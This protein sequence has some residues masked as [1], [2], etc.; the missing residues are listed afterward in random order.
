ML[1]PYTFLQWLI[2][3]TGY[4]SLF[5]GA[6]VFSVILV[7]ILLAM[8]NNDRKTLR[9]ENPEAYLL[10]KYRRNFGTQRAV[11]T[12]E[13]AVGTARGGGEEGRSITLPGYTV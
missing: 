9:K 8:R 3:F 4:L 2:D 11:D 13:Y 6:S 12:D 1:S 7:P 5:T 10:R